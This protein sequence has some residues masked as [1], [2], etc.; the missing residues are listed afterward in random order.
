MQKSNLAVGLLVA[1]A[2]VVG[3]TSL[4]SRGTDV[5]ASV[6]NAVRT[7]VLITYSD[8]GFT[9][10]VVKITKGTSLR[11][12]NTSNNALRIAPLVDPA[13]NEEGYRGFE[14]SQSIKQG[15]SFELSII[16]SG[17]WGFTNKNNPGAVGV[18]IVE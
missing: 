16:R 1:A 13:F 6:G 10:A 18:V 17:V 7:P 3:F 8:T 4:Q 11:I 12:I 9:P 14:S 15:D 5:T 2:L